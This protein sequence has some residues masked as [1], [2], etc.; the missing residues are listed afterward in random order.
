MI[1]LFE[2]LRAGQAKLLVMSD[3]ERLR[4]FGDFVSLPSAPEWL[5]PLVAILPA[6]LF[7]YHLARARGLDTENPRNITK[8]TLTK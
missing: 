8:V 3:D 7:A 5:A 1:E 2:R 4:Y 6:Q